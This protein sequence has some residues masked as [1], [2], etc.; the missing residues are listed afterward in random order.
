MSKTDLAARLEELAGFARHMKLCG[1]IGGYNRCTC[2]LEEVEAHLPDIIAALRAG[3]TS[4]PGWA[5]LEYGSAA[6]CAQKRADSP[7]FP[8]FIIGWYQR[9]DSEARGYVL[10]HDPDR[11]VHVYPEAATEPRALPTPPAKETPND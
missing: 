5:A 8:G 3:E 6:Q 2:G 10:Q 1:I 11:I 4:W 9:L 7:A